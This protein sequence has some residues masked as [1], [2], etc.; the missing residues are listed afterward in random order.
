[1]QRHSVEV[2]Q[3]RRV[4]E[5]AFKNVAE[6]AYNADRSKAQVF[7]GPAAR[8]WRPHGSDPANPPETMDTPIDRNQIRREQTAEA[9]R[10]AAS[11]LMATTDPRRVRVQEIASEAGVSVG[12]IYFHFGTKDALYLTLLES[13]LDLSARYTLNRRWSDSPLQRVFNVGEA[14]IGFALENPEAF[15]LITQRIPVPP[16]DDAINRAQHRIERSISKEINAI[17]ADLRAAVEAGEV[18]D[19]PVEHMLTFL[20]ASWAGVIGMAFRE[21]AFR[22]GPK[23]IRVVLGGAS[24]ILARGI[25]PDG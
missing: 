10:S 1:M 24:A 5:V 13:A 20:W 3:A 12:T 23:E 8:V 16:G 6:C 11:R 17:A 19:L 21:D 22:I 4:F 14:Y 7:R 9:I 15:R 25:R 18:L 2:A